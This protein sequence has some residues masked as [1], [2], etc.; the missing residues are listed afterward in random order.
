MAE[1]R[2]LVALREL[3]RQIRSFDE[4]ELTIEHMAYLKRIGFRSAHDFIEQ[5]RLTE[6]TTNRDVKAFR[7]ALAVDGEQGLTLGQRRD[8]FR[9]A[10]NVSERTLIRRE[11]AG[12]A[13]L[14]KYLDAPEAKPQR[15]V[16]PKPQGTLQDRVERLEEEVERLKALLRAAGLTDE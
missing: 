14:L 10:V 13:W 4:D 3:S 6:G 7:N 15:F 16:P 9:Q 5:V 8:R 1:D 12:A 11:A 2:R